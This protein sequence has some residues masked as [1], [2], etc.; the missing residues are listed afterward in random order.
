MA[1][2][3]CPGQVVLPNAKYG[4]YPMLSIPRFSP[5]EIPIF[6]FQNG[7]H[8]NTNGELPSRST[9][10]NDTDYCCV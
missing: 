6:D 1:V 7:R 3:L 9:T 5:L 4:I 8:N 10:I 2:V